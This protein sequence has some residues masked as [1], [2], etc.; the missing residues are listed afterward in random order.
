M[1]RLGLGHCGLGLGPGRVHHP[2]QGG[3]LEVLDVGEQ[4]A[5]GFEPDGV[6]VTSGRQP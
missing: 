1:G 6:E 2:D 5:F 4:V 3:H